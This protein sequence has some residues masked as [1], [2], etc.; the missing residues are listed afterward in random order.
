MSINRERL[1]NFFV[2]YVRYDEDAW[3]F[4]T[5]KSTL[6][7]SSHIDFMILDSYGVMISYDPTQFFKLIY[8]RFLIS[9]TIKDQTIYFT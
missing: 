8:S 6:L 3:D 4:F 2:K 1:H 9:A 5:A 7:K